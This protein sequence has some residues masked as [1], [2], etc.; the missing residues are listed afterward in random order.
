VALFCAFAVPTQITA[1]PQ[2]AARNDVD[3]TVA[4]RV[5]V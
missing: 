2:R 5:E 4:P 1:R 3:L